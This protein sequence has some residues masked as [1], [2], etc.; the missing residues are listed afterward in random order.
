MAKGNKTFWT[1]ER[2]GLPPLWSITFTP[3]ISY[4]KYY[5]QTGQ[6]RN[7]YQVVINTQ[8]ISL[9]EALQQERLQTMLRTEV[10]YDT[11]KKIWYDM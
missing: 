1:W 2:L 10:I 7:K 11:Y 3:Y 9:E 4:F 5:I 6:E 8:R